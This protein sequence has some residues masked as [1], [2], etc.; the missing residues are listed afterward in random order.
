MFYLNDS[1]EIEVINQ[2]NKTRH[3]VNYRTEGGNSKERQRVGEL[4][5]SRH[6]M[7]S[8]IIQ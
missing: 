8:W 2:L 7:D 4:D 3:L 6:V 5:W 1:L